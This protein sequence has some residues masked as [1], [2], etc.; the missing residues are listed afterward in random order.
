[1]SV[2][3]ERMIDGVFRLVAFHSGLTEVRLHAGDRLL[4]D[5]GIDGDDASELMSAFFRMFPVDPCD[6]HFRDHFCDEGIPLTWPFLMIA[7]LIEPPQLRAIT[8]GDLVRAAHE[9]RWA[10]S[11]T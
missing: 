9:R 6:F 11:V 1:V 3:D 4:H 8:I 7:N 10:S 5:L 2:L